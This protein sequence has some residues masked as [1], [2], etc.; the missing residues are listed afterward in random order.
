MR[1]LLAGGGTAGHV[2]PALN[3]AEVL[4]ARDPELEATF[5][6]TQRGLESRLVPARGFTLECINAV[7]MPR[8]PSRDLV[9][10]PSRVRGA[11]AQTRRI[12]DR[13]DC[14]VVVGFGGYVALP[15]YLAAR[16]RIPIVVHEANARAGLANRVGARLTPFVALTVPGS[17]RRGRVIGLPLRDGIATLDR[18]AQ[19]TAARETLG[20]DPWA[21]C[22]LVFGGSQGARRVNQELIS[23]APELIAAGTQVL[24]AVGSGNLD[25][26]EA[27]PPGLRD[28]YRTV[29]YL[30]RMDLAYAAADLAVCR[31]G[32]MTCAEL[33]AVGLPAIYVP[34]PIGNGE[35]RRNA[36]PV[37]RAGGGILVPDRE[38]TRDVVLNRVLPLL[39][40]SD[41]LREMSVAAAGH[42]VRDAGERLADLVELARDSAA[43]P[44]AGA[45]AGH[46]E[47]QGPV[48]GWRARRRGRA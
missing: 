12:I 3:L 44:A 32:A 42:G 19:R 18:A 13:H 21:P 33:A 16:H 24:H 45:A 48:A 37:V 28:R 46:G 47:N 8:R 10:V 5:L 6:G 7:A 25:Q 1:V 23:A 15:A 36:L 26:A 17:L 2:E 20:L 38:L 22:L 31:S 27:V 9:A 30:D 4:R 41:R 43:L 34:L 39:A 29:S 40:D 14:E 11:V 35:Q